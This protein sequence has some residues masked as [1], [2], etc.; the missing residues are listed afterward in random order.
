MEKMEKIIH[1]VTVAGDTLGNVVMKSHNNSE[2]GYI[3]VEQ[4]KTSFESNGFMR[5]T[6]ISALIHGRI[7]DLL[8][9]EWQKDQ[10]IP[11]KIIFR[12]SLNPF[13]PYDLLKDLKIA[14]K[15]GV[16]CKLNGQPIYRKTFYTTKMS[17][18]DVTIQH[19]NND[20]I[21]IARAK[22]QNKQ[23]NISDIAEL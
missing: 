7:D 12:E 19:N 8:A 2:W 14:G 17:M 4:L 9:L 15:T 23:N 10:E 3:R 6:P 13:H 21:K 5:V 20:E 1:P 22:L 16:S 11:G 18:E